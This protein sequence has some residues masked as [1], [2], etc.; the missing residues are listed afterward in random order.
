MSIIGNNILAGASGQGGYEIQRGLRFNDG[1]TAYLNKTFSSAGNRQAWT[2]SAWVKQGDLGTGR[3]VLFGAYGATNNSDLLEVGFETN[4]IYATIN[5]VLTN[6][7]YRFRDPSAW[8]HYVVNYN[9]SYMKWYINGEEAHSWARTGN[10]G[11]NGDF[12]HTIGR[13]AF[14]SI[15]FFDGYLAEINFIDGQTLDGS[16]FA[17]TDS[18]TGAWIPKKYSGSFGTNG[19]NLNFSDNSDVTA[20][21]LGKDS[22]GNGNNFT[23]NNFSVTAGA[24]ND[25]LEDTPTN[26]WCTLNPLMVAGGT[27][28]TLS[29]GNLDVTTGSTHQW[30]TG[31][32][33]IS[34]GKWYVEY[35]ATTNSNTHG[36]GIRANT[37]TN[38]PMYSET[39]AY[40]WQFYDTNY[41]DGGSASSYGSRP[42]AGSIVAMTIDLD[43]GTIEFFVNNVSQGQKTG[44]AL[45]DTYK[46][47]WTASGQSGSFNFGQHGFSYT[48]TGFKALNTANL[49]VPTVK[50]GT[51]YFDTK[52]WTGNGTSQTISGLSFQ[53]DLAWLKARS[54]NYQHSVY[55]AVRGASAGR[56]ATDQTL[57]EV[58]RGA[59][60]PSFTSDGITVRNTLNDNASGQ[61][62]VGWFWKA[63]GSGSANTDGTI[64]STVSVNADAGF[65][66]V[67]YTGNATTGATV[68]HGLSVTPNMYVIKDR[69]SVSNW[70]VFNDNLTTNNNLYLNTADAQFAAGGFAGMGATS[71][72]I[73]LPT[74]GTS[75][76][77]ESGKKYIAYCFS[78][79]EG[80]S[81]FGSYTGNGSS[82][83]GTFVYTGFKP[84]FITMRSVSTSTDWQIKDDERD[85]YNPVRSR[86]WANLGNGEA[87]GTDMDFLSNGFKIKE[88]GN[89]TNQSG[90]AYIYM[91]FAETPFKY[92][93]AA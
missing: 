72:L 11:I 16:S 9:G 3:Q 25:S 62:F 76:V 79:V 31:T 77:N 24:G 21:T 90:V 43:N 52:L 7:T 46:I 82:S 8:F 20:T 88:S 67:S 50:N 78:E 37:T 54:V 55:D 10:L 26:N 74:G 64:S 53:P 49:P 84:A 61:T 65:S 35:T 48:K 1:D 81:K 83:D 45:G 71:S 41:Y 30:R 87:Q 19:F 29:N 6:G 85:L 86:L 12:S 14:S 15:R 51:E 32:I 33:G 28:S 39:T 89:A 75:T 60:N 47:I 69:D 80:Y 66:I 13:S 57:T 59:N 92:A 63:G 22:S 68:G 4:G 18:D 70:L 56:L 23:P 38:T 2:W 5:T 93:N 58:D 91:A 17:E 44:I 27:G 73:Q 42:N 40:Y 36:I 34:S